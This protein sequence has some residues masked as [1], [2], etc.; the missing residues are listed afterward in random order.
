VLVTDIDRPLYT[1]SFW[2]FDPF[3]SYAL[4]ITKRTRAFLQ[5]NVNNL[6][7]T[8]DIYPV[9]AYSTALDTT[10]PQLATYTRGAHA[11]FSLQEPR[12]VNLSLT[13]NF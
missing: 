12:L 7:N 10:R 5:L 2:Y 13:V 1:P 11:A 3:V 8:D 6:L 9:Q 4:R